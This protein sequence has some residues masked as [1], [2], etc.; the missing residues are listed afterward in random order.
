MNAKITRTLEWSSNKQLTVSDLTSLVEWLA[1]A[2]LRDD[3]Q[4]FIRADDNQKDGY[5]FKATV[6]VEEQDTDHC[7][8]RDGYC[9]GLCP[10]SMR[11]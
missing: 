3:Q 5:W 10:Y 1:H 6:V 7:T 8:C 9:L 2:G 4:V 11:S